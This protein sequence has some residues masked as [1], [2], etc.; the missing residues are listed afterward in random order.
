MQVW[1]YTNLSQLKRVNNVNNTSYVRLDAY[2]VKATR[3]P[4]KTPKIFGSHQLKQ[5]FCYQTIALTCRNM[6]HNI[7][8]GF[9]LHF[10]A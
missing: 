7:V 4:C 3:K 9:H 6:V 5:Y 10:E 1:Y 8:F 2:K